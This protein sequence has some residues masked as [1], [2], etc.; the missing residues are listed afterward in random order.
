MD[1]EKRFQL[2]AD[3]ADAK[4]PSVPITAEAAEQTNEISKQEL[5]WDVAE[6]STGEGSRSGG[7]YQ[8]LNHHR[9]KSSPEEINNL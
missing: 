6:S 3:E 7:L 8:T 5:K 1:K 4:S 2:M 9:K